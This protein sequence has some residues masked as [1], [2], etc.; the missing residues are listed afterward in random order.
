MPKNMIVHPEESFAKRKIKLK[1][2][3]VCE[4]DKTVADEK[5]NFSKEDFLGMYADM[6]AIR[7]F[8]SM[9]MDIKKKGEYNGKK[10]TYP[11][12]SHLG[13]GEE[14]TAV[15]QAYELGVDDFIFGTHR[16]HHEVIAKAM[17]AIKKL[18]DEEL[19]NIME[20]Y[21]EGAVYAVV[22]K[23]SEAKTVKD[24]AKDYFMYGLM[25]ELFAKDMGFSRGLGG[26]MHA[27]FLP[28]GIYPN[29]AI[30]GGAGPI[31]TGVALFKKCN[32]KP[33][34]VIANAGD[35]A[36]GRGPVFEAMNFAAMDQYNELW[37]EGYKGGLPII[38]NFNNNQYG[39]DDQTRGET[40]A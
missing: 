23:Y 20:N 31:A 38:F 26:S 39:M 36:A 11:G 3:P 2:I 37:E 40:M 34:I 17:S 35:G 12:P 32:K 5:D 18:S 10:F 13:L 19:T 24:L 7:E 28:F 29:N 1:D 15:G 33:G 22:K 16:S 14:A 30:V 6:V 9:L 27:F 21:H 8:E 25:C 4:Y